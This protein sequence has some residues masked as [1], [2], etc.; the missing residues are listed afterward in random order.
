VGGEEVEAE[1]VDHSFKKFGRG[2]QERKRSGIGGGSAVKQRVSAQGN[3][4][5]EHWC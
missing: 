3:W 2:G 1:G 4:R 5:E